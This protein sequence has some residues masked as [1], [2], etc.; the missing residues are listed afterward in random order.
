QAEDGIRDRNVTGVQTCALPIC[1]HAN[2]TGK[3]AAE[4]L[5]DLILG[6]ATVTVDLHLYTASDLANAPVW[7]SGIGWLDSC[8]GEKWTARTKIGRASCRERGERR[9]VA[10]DTRE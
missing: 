2:A 5:V 6:K 7:A 4:A 1:N 10:G 8:T 9:E 3:T